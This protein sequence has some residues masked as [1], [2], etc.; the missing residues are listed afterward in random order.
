MAYVKTVWQTGDVITAA[1]LNNAEDGIEALQPLV[2]EA[3]VEVN[4][5]TLDTKAG[6]IYTAFSSGKPIVLKYEHVI[7][8]SETQVEFYPLIV[9][10][11]NDTYP[12]PY[13]FQ[14]GSSIEVVAET[15]DTYPHTYS[16]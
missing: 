16:E 2:V 14:F 10:T 9:M 1:K 11:Y 5:Y 8:E 6:V 13:N 3:T 4:I 15:A 12:T 7:S